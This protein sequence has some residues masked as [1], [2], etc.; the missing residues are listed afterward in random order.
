MNNYKP[1]GSI[2]NKYVKSIME[3]GIDGWFTTE[4]ILEPK[5]N[6]TILTWT[7]DE[8]VENLVW[9]YIMLGVE[10]QLGPMYES[11]FKRF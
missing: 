11:G 7:Y 10:G 8:K 2:E 5:D 6:Q 1:D 3:F 9:R 4:F